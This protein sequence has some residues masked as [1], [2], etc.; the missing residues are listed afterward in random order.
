[1]NV[2]RKLICGLVGICCA[3]AI[4]IVT[5]CTPWAQLPERQ[6]PQGSRTALRYSIPRERPEGEVAVGFFGLEDD[7][8]G[9][10][11]LHLQMEV[12]N[13]SGRPWRV[14]ARQLIAAVPRMGYVRPSYVG[15]RPVRPPLVT[16]PAANQGVI[17][18]LFAL[19]GTLEDI[20]SWS[21]FDF[22]WCVDAEGPWACERSTI[23]TDA[24]ESEGTAVPRAMMYYWQNDDPEG[25]QRLRSGS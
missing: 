4:S 11:N 10:P 25:L 3:N 16:I 14:D 21:Q 6:F 15:S 1:V 24:T 22:I 18:L 13:Y 23:E 20:E 19:S 8:T 12:L 7:E 17:D 9:T 2:P 5:G